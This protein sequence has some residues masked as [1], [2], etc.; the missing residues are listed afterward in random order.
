[1]TD[2]TPSSLTIAVIAVST[3]WLSSFAIAQDYPPAPPF[4]VRLTQVAQAPEPTLIDPALPRPNVA[5]PVALHPDDL[6]PADASTAVPDADVEAFARGPVHEAFA[7]VYDL[8]P[9]TSAVIAKAPPAVVEELPP[10]QA[11]TGDNVQWISGYWN[12]DTEATDFIW[13]SGV[14]RNVPPGRRWVPG[15]WAEVMGGFQWVGG[16]WADAQVQELTYVPTPPPSL[17]VGPNVPPPGADQQ[18][19]PGNWT[20]VSNDY[21][22]SPGYYTPCQQ[23]FMWVPN[24]YCDTPSGCVFVPGYLDYRFAHR[25]TLFSPVR[26]LQPFD[27][28]GFDGPACYRPR[29]SVNM[30]GFMI[31]L[32]VRPRCRNFYYGDYYG[33][34][35]AGLGFSPWHRR[36][37]GNRGFHDP[38]LNFYRWDSNRRGIDFDRSVGNWHQRYETNSLIRPPRMIRD[39]DQFLVRHRGDRA[40]EL[41]VMSNRFEDVVRNPRAGEAFHKMERRDIELL[42]ENSRVNRTVET[43][44]RQLERDSRVVRSGELQPGEIVDLRLK[45]VRERVGREVGRDAAGD[46]VDE[47]RVPNE[48]LVLTD[49]P[50]RLKERTRDSAARVERVRP[51]PGLQLDEQ[52]PKEGSADA[53]RGSADERAAERARTRGQADV[54]RGRPDR[55]GPNGKGTPPSIDDRSKPIVNDTVGN[56]PDRSETR[57]ANGNQDEAA[58]R[59]DEIRQRI[60]ERRVSRE[61][62]PAGPSTDGS[63]GETRERGTPR[64]V[65]GRPAIEVKP[66]PQSDR[67]AGRVIEDSAARQRV[68][69]IRQQAVDRR[70]SR[71]NENPRERVA[72]APDAVNNRVPRAT[73]RVPQNEGAVRER[74]IRERETAPRIE[75]SAPVIRQQP[76]ERPQRIERAPVERAPRQIERQVPVERA[77]QQIQRAPVERAPRQIERAPVERAPRQVER[78]PAERAPRGERNP[79]G[80][81]GNN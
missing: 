51:Q 16:F 37:F 45:D 77:P 63:K 22:W 12:W 21:R 71:D 80:R 20:Y 60:E 30:A 7:D 26:F 74:V 17:E 72:P 61:A 59:M 66:D 6:P 78:A 8:N 48:K 33:N 9:V 19:V 40:A 47:R 29:Y 65:E 81:R 42:Q 64:I 39:Q 44:R 57:G 70:Q 79:S 67:A 76:M 35:Y 3:Q 14:W 41:A 1:M 68:E 28:Y 18:W 56:R 4:S 75:N 55:E 46:R 54:E 32:F 25:G 31:H 5:A 15:Y 43:A 2:R 52:P 58:A 53:I 36:S 73:E 23:D 50:E 62:G 38:A 11:P 10:E 27:S 49:L 13:V 34:Q 69:E 24:Q